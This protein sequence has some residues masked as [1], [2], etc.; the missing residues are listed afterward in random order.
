MPEYY[1]A[2]FGV[3]ETP[4]TSEASWE[5]AD[6]QDVEDLIGIQALKLISNEPGA[7][8]DSVTDTARIQRVGE[9]MDQYIDARMA[10]LGYETP[11]ANMSTGTVL[12]MASVSAQLVAYKL[13]E[14]R[15]LAS[16]ST[17]TSRNANVIDKLM[18]Q[19]RKTAEMLLNKI[20]WRQISITADRLYARPPF[21]KVH[22]PSDPEVITAL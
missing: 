1:G 16:L 6:Q 12:L 14:P 19:H 17:P 22:I 8:S 15:M 18:E 4:I 2:Y 10:V 13:N 9:L 7:A 5:Y 3:S 21:A 11:L 20:A